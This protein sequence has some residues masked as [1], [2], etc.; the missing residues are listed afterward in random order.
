MGLLAVIR[1][2]DKIQTVS[3]LL[4]ALVLVGGRFADLARARCG[5]AS[6]GQDGKWGGIFAASEL[7]L[8]ACTSVIVFLGMLAVNSDWELSWALNLSCCAGAVY[9]LSVIVEP[10]RE[11]MLSNR[12]MRAAK[13]KLWRKYATNQEIRDAIWRAIVALRTEPDRAFRE[14]REALQVWARA[15]RVIGENESI[16]EVVKRG[17]PPLIVEL[18]NDLNISDEEF[19]VLWASRA[20]TSEAKKLIKSL[21]RRWVDEAIMPPILGD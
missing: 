21:W 10:L 3:M 1:V 8:L 20:G 9:L 5:K 19:C 7:F 12:R 11:Y 15:S 16:E 13:K 14:A 17:A 18:L 4:A 6:E 2:E